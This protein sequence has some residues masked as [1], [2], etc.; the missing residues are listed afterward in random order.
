MKNAP[1]ALNNG[2]PTS[3][4]MPD[5]FALIPAVYTT[6]FTSRPGTTTTFLTG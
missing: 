5:S 3:T 6:T 2:D 1:V 4:F